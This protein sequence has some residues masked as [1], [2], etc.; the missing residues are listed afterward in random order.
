MNYLV[1]QPDTHRECLSR[2]YTFRDPGGPNTG[3]LRRRF[4]D[5]RL[6]GDTHALDGIPK[7]QYF[8]LGA[9][10]PADA[11]GNV[12]RSADRWPPSDARDTS[13]YLTA[14]NGLSRDAPSATPGTLEFAADPDH[15]YPTWGG[16][17][18]SYNVPIGPYDQR[19]RSEGRTDLLQFAS[20]PLEGPVEIA[21]RVRVKLYVSTDAPDTDFTAKLVDIYPEPDGKVINIIDGI[22]RLKYRRSVERTE[23]Y[24]PGTVMDL[25]IDLWS[26]SFVF[27]PGH[28]IG[29]HI[30]G[31]NAPRFSVNPNTG[32][33]YIEE[34]APAAIAH[35]TV[36]LSE[37]C[38]SALI[39][40]ECPWRP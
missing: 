8:T 21:G 14:Q 34:G 5:A 12:W 18:L 20:P 39:L 27:A 24:T 15:P 32:A 25:E 7:V 40:P 38:P 23:P 11:P 6:R 13:F 19:A 17:N 36:H 35:N 33:D 4:F 22:Q 30:A 26:T 28:R 3:D 1:M 29:L 9:D 10:T 37:D 2:D 16:A 31:S